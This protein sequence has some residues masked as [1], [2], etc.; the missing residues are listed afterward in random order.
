MENS[1]DQG[2]DPERK[3]FMDEVRRYIVQTI[4]F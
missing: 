4:Q 1:N 2:I 3:K